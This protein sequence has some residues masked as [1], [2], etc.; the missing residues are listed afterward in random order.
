[1]KIGEEIRFP[2]NEMTLAHAARSLFA[3]PDNLH[4][5]ANALPSQVNE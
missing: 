2:A 3:A 1:M 5:K 4:C